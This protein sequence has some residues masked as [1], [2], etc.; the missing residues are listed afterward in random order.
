MHHGEIIHSLLC[1]LVELSAC[2]WIHFPRLLALFM[3]IP[4][5]IFTIQGCI[6]CIFRLD[7]RG[8]STDQVFST[9][10]PH[11]LRVCVCACV[12]DR[13]CALYV[14]LCVFVVS[15]FDTVSP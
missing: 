2:S 14:V 12:S 5:F 8:I 6:V 15:V 13:K 7:I 4:N 3:Y 1:V 9:T 10:T 11:P